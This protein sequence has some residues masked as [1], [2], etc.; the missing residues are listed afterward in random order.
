MLRFQYAVAGF[1]ISAFIGLLIGM[2]EM[3]FID[4]EKHAALL[5]IVMALTIISSGV[6]GMI[7][8]VKIASKKMKR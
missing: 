1:F 2:I 5:F 8:A 6:T 3:R 4:A 7:I